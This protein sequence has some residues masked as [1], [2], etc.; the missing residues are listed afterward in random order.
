MSSDNNENI[1]YERDIINLWNSLRNKEDGYFAMSS[2]MQKHGDQLD[3][4]IDVETDSY[5]KNLFSAWTNRAKNVFLEAVYNSIDSDKVKLLKRLKIDAIWWDKNKGTPHKKGVDLEDIL[6]KIQN[7]GALMGLEKNHVLYE[8]WCNIWLDRGWIK[9]KK[10]LNEFLLSAILFDNI[11]VVKKIISEYEI[12]V[13]ADLIKEDFPHS[14]LAYKII[15]GT[16]MKLGYFARS[17]EMAKVLT[18]F[19]FDWSA[20]V[21]DKATLLD[22]VRNRASENFISVLEH[23]KVITLISKFN[24]KVERVDKL[25]IMSDILQG[26]TENDNIG[27]VLGSVDWSDIRGQNGENLAHVIAK[28]APDI[29]FDSQYKY[30]ITKEFIHLLNTPDDN[31]IYPFELFLC[32]ARK[33]MAENSLINDIINLT[34]KN[35]VPEPDWLTVK[36]LIAENQAAYSA[37][38]STPIDIWKQKTPEDFKKC[39]ESESGRRLLEIAPNIIPKKR[40][41]DAEEDEE[42]EEYDAA[43]CGMKI[44]SYV[45]PNFKIENCFELAKTKNEVKLCLVQSLRFF[46]ENYEILDDDTDT[47]ICKSIGKLIDKALDLNISVSNIRN[48]TLDNQRDKGEINDLMC[49]LFPQWG[50]LEIIEERNSLLKTFG[51]NIKREKDNS[52]GMVL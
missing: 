13:N 38:D 39:L 14:F 35:E 17:E 18:G 5:H 24:L 30:V 45:H 47:K 44:L 20:P 52:I 16:T 26:V 29:A 51:G 19:G 48:Q 9:E 15:P 37:V 41:Y 12:D 49:E 50:R 33:S 43:F 46:Y 1:E 21:C 8:E 3:G 42:N 31:G 7:E 32:F 34:Q 10:L 11:N 28:H 25:S 36:L 40:T 23:T 6:P 4:F 2:I 27:E 22:A